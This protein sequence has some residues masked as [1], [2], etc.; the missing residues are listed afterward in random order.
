MENITHHITSLLFDHD[1]VVLPGLGGFVTSYHTAQVNATTHLFYP[2]SKTILF[3]KNLINNDGLLI[4]KVANEE[5]ITYFEASTLVTEYVN[6]VK[7]GLLQQRRFELKGLGVIYLDVEQNTQFIQDKNHNYLQE[8]FGLPI[9]K[10]KPLAQQS[11]VITPIKETK[12][13]IDRPAIEQQKEI[14]I[15]PV[16]SKTAFK[17]YRAALITVPAIA[18]IGLLIWLPFKNGN[19]DL[20][21]SGFN[22]FSSSSTIKPIV[23]T[24][25]ENKYEQRVAL[26]EAK[27][28]SSQIAIDS[29]K[30]I[31][32]QQKVALADTTR[33]YKTVSAQIQQTQLLNFYLVAGCF[34]NEENA[35]NYLQQLHQKGYKNA[36]ILPN[37]VNDLIRVVYG[38]YASKWEATTVKD[39]IATTNSNVW[40]LKEKI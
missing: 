11:A 28:K 10:V 13:F 35:A 18:L 30:Q 15:T 1:C 20:N 32:Q 6:N 37:K 17:K 16:Q 8:A 36:F 3:N 26:A 19:Q 34:A 22:I 23:N 24:T 38:K 5:A 4:H 7:N 27:V 40:I 33:V 25:S 12:T 39:S 29:L 2:P 14:A 21:T 9:F 31:I